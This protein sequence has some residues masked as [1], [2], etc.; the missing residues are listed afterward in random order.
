VV[1]PL[2]ELLRPLRLTAVVDIGAN[3]IDGDP[4]Y[5]PM[6]GNGLCTV[7]GF[8]PQPDAFAELNRCKGPLE[9][10]LPF[11]LGD[12]TDKVLYIC[13]ANGMTSCLRPDATHLA[14]FNEFPSLAR[15]E[16]ETIIKTSRLDDLDEITEIDFLKID[17]QGA[18]L[19]ILKS[20]QQKLSKAVAIQTEVSFVTLY[21]NQP[22]IGL[23]DTALR[24]MGFV[25]HCFAEI[26]TWPIAPAVIDGNPRKPLRQLLEADLVY[27]RDFSRSE[28]M[29]GEQWKHLALIAHHCYGSFDLAMCAIKTAVQLGVLP[30]R[31]LQLYLEIL[32]MEQSKRGTGGPGTKPGGDR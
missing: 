4:P 16:H 31:A 1:D 24:E 9:R 13:R 25:P 6:L 10:Y 11:A 27:V 5:K 32:A 8:E 30:L 18:E 2:H 28:N 26:K 15:V 23:V 7:T 12:G 14:L 19:E 29:D 17:V 20:G 3:P 21:H 22:P